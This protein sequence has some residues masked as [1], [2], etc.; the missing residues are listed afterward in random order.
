MAH[1]IAAQVLAKAGYGPSTHF[2]SS[3]LLPEN[4]TLSGLIKN[5]KLKY[6]L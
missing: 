4:R 3:S 1:V 5:E 2:C 6:T